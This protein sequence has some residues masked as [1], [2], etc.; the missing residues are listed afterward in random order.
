MTPDSAPSEGTSGD[1]DGQALSEAD[2]EDVAQGPSDAVERSKFGALQLN[3]DALGNSYEY[4]DSEK[5]LKA[6]L[7]EKNGERRL[8]LRIRDHE[9][10]RK[11]NE[12]TVPIESDSS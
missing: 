5:N 3:P 7:W 10:G 1:D 8:Y 4:L 12:F 6:K 11:F 9:N 2:A